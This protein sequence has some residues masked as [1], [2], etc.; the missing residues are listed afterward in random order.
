MATIEVFTAGCGCCDE[1][2]RTVRAASC[3]SCT[4]VVRDMS[5]ASDAATAKEYGI[6][7][8]PAVVVDGKIADCCGARAVDASALRALGV[9]AG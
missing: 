5:N 3:P 4:I 6:H 7:R 1:A 2:V 8:V 9:G